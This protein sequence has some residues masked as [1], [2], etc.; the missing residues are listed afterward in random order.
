M[1][2]F[3]W[4]RFGNNRISEH[5]HNWVS[6]MDEEKSKGENSYKVLKT[7]RKWWP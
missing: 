6:V 1:T 4:E 5:L 3:F 2:G 7:E